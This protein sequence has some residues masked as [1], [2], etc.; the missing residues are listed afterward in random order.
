MIPYQVSSYEVDASAIIREARRR[1]GLSQRELARRV[2]TS[3]SA[4]ARYE[5]AM[6]SPSVRSLTRILRAC[7]FDLRA[8]LVPHGAADDALIDMMLALSVE[9]RLR[10]AANYSRLV[11]EL[12]GG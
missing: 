4:I 7:G 12:R 1:G 11:S 10:T 8:E 3:Q 5:R 2:G 6:T 9:D